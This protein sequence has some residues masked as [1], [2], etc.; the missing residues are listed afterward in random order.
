MENDKCKHEWMGTLNVL[1]KVCRH[2]PA[3]QDYVNEV[4]PWKT[5]KETN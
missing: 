3:K 4:L 1:V 5:R 2:C